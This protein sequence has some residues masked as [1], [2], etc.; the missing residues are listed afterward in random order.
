MPEA[1]LPSTAY[2]SWSARREASSSRS[3][4]ARAI[5]LKR[6]N[7]RSNS[8][9]TCCRFDSG[10]G[11]ARPA[12]T[13]STY[14]LSTLRGFSMR[15]SAKEPIAANPSARQALTASSVSNTC[16]R[17]R[18]NSEMSISAR[19][20]PTEKPSSRR[21]RASH[22]LPD[23]VSMISPSWAGNRRATSAGTGLCTGN[24]NGSDAASTFPLGSATIAKRTLSPA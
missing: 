24:F 2:F 15:L 19:I 1:S 14:P 13:R 8:R 12:R 20:R 4:S 16:L 11:S 5:A 3:F 17:T 18:S 21:E 7:N 23:A 22:A 6:S 10:M 9:E